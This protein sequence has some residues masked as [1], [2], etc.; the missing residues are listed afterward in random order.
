MWTIF[1]FLLLILDKLTALLFLNLSKHYPRKPLSDEAIMVNVHLFT[2]FFIYGPCINQ[3]WLVPTS[4]PENPPLHI[5]IL[6]VLVY[7][8]SIKRFVFKC[9]PQA[10]FCL[11]IIIHMEVIWIILPFLSMPFTSAIKLWIQSITLMFLT[12]NIK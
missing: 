7:N 11:S 2:Y 4:V 12:T 5:R 1:L 10:D 8:I 9:K 6:V 3:Y